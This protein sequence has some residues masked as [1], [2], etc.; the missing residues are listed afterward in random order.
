M[1][2]KQLTKKERDLQELDLPK[3][4][5][6]DPRKARF[7]IAYFNQDSPVHGNMKQSAIVAGFSEEYANNLS[8]LMPKWLSDFIGRRD[9]GTEAENHMRMVMSLP[10]VKQAM[11]P[12]GPIEKTE[13]ITEDTGEVYKSGKKKGQRKTRKKKIKVPVLVYD[14][15]MIK[16]KTAV[17]KIV[18]P[19]YKPDVYGKK[20]GS[21]VKFSYNVHEV[22]QRYQ[23][24]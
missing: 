10:I 8:A 16:E 13:T 20:E 22:R 15:S 12:F 21:S 6:E 14:V 24:S 18:L 17:S 9:L 5:R 2:R 7:L 1:A 4:V 3:S 23:P 19:A 11:G